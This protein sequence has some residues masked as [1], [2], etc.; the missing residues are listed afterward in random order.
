MLE[1]VSEWAAQ[2]YQVVGDASELHSQVALLPENKVLV[3]L[4]FLQQR[5]SATHG[6]LLTH[7]FKLYVGSDCCIRTTHISLAYVIHVATRLRD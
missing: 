5:V 2:P 7:T 4:V 3:E 6:A 1:L